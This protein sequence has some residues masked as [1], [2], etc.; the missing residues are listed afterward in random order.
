LSVTA[1]PRARATLHYTGIYLEPIL[2]PWVTTPAFLQLQFY[3]YKC[4]LQAYF[5][6][7]IYHCNLL[8]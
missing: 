2:R 1:L 3:Y 8:V 6:I 4:N 7:V 5:T